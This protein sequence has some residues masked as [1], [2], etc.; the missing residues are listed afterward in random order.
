MKAQTEK[1]VSSCYASP[2]GRIRLV[3]STKGICKL[4]LPAES[5]AE[6][7]A[8]LRR[9]VGPDVLVEE[10]EKC[11]QMPLLQEAARQLEAYFAAHLQNFDL[12]LDLRGT[13]FQ[14]QVWRVVG[15][16]PYAV[17]KTYKDIALEVRNVKAVR[18]VGA[19]NGSNPL[20]I[21]VPCHRVIGTNGKLV[22]YG[23]GLEL[24][25]KLLAL[26]GII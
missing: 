18:A 14:R 7:W 13:E 9:V 25:Q 1:F 11:Q 10:V 3:A 6:V 12:A 26:E 22:G 17:I 19:A 2:W 16:I 8:W 24:K 21:V 4:G 5:D 15:A 20:P 23:G